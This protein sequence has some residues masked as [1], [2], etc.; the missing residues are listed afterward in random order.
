MIFL[1]IKVEFVY[2][3]LAL[4]DRHNNVFNFILIDRLIKVVDIPHLLPDNTITYH[5]IRT[6]E[7]FFEH[8]EF[9]EQV[10]KE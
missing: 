4:I 8:K 5:L 2:S 7:R 1:R 10:S 3:V 6:V 9:L